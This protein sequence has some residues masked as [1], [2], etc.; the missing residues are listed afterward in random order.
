MPGPT[1]E[2]LLFNRFQEAVRDGTREEVVE[3][4]RTPS[5]PL[6]FRSPTGRRP[7]HLV[8]ERGH[9]EAVTL[10][11]DMGAEMRAVDNK[12]KTILHYAAKSGNNAV[13]ADLLERGLIPRGL[14]GDILPEDAPFQEIH[15]QDKSGLSFG[16]ETPV[17]WAVFA[18]KMDTARFILDKAEDPQ[19]LVD[20]LDNDGEAILHWACQHGRIGL[21]RQMASELGAD[22]GKGTAMGVTPLHLAAES[23]EME[24]VR[25]LVEELGVPV[26]AQ[27]KHGDTP[28]HSAV[29][30]ESREVVDYLLSRPGCSWE[31]RNVDG[32]TAEDVAIEHRVA[33]GIQALLEGAREGHLAEVRERLLSDGKEAEKIR[34]A[35][36][37]AKRISAQQI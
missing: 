26:D 3:I 11:L 37:M 16:T 18:H 32:H 25:L 17:H 2:Q 33:G 31:T 5:F 1:P 8:C 9:Y 7:L 27:D 34:K 36:A 35:V 21:V 13:V 6:D 22:P 30:F 28:L 24:M 29:H 19:S 10:L 23:G 15:E 4:I 14:P 12:G 20:A